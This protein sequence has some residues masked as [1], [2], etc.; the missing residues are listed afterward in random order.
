MHGSIIRPNLI[1]EKTIIVLM[2][3]ADPGNFARGGCVH[4]RLL[5]KTA[6]TMFFCLSPQLILQF[7]SGLYMF[8][9]K[10]NY[11]FSRVQRGPKFSRGVRHFPGGF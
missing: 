9:F 3:C 2:T 4:A 5:K 10:E 6:L 11:N 1:P 8:F 7:N